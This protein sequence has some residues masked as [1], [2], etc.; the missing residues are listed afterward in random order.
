MQEEEA[1][2]VVDVQLHHEPDHNVNVGGN[3]KT[4][5]ECTEQNDDDGD[6]AKQEAAVK[7]QAS[8][9]GW[10]TRKELGKV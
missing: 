5:V 8:F 6:P 7:I 3:A 2:D 1:V 9:R 4:P 10:K